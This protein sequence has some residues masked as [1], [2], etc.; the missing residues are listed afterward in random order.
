MVD[1]IWVSASN[2]LVECRQFGADKIWARMY[3]E[4]FQG[5]RTLAAETF[6]E[7]LLKYDSHAA[8]GWCRKYDEERGLAH[9]QSNN[10]A[11][12]ILTPTVSVRLNVG[13]NYQGGG[14]VDWDG[15]R[16]PDL[17]LWQMDIRFEGL[18]VGH[19]SLTGLFGETARPVFDDEEIETTME[20]HGALRG[21]VE[22]YRVS[23]ALGTDFTL[24]GQE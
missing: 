21:E 24:S 15:R 10:A 7:W 13:V 6:E 16:I 20:V 2:L 11:F 17:E 12:K 22:D 4:F 19:Q 8:P 5:R 1:G 23:G 9:V 14:E 18:K 3:E